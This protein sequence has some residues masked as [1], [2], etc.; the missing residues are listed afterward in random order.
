MDVKEIKENIIKCIEENYNDN[1]VSFEKS[2]ERDF[3]LFLIDYFEVLRKGIVAQKRTVHISRELKNKVK[4]SVFKE[5]RKRF[6]EI[7]S[8]IE[9]GDDLNPFLS[10][11]AKESGFKDRLLTCWNMHHLHFY[12][13][14]KSGDMLLFAIVKDDTVY[15]I[16]VIPHSKKYIFSTFELLNIV[17]K[18]WRFLLEPYRI[19]DAIS[20]EYVIKTDEE[21]NKLRSAGIS[22]AIQIDKNI[23]ALDMMST[24]G[25]NA[26]DVMYANNILNT[27]RIN[28]RNGAL[29]KMKLV[30]LAL[31]GKRKP[32]FILTYEDEQHNLLPWVI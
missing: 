9:N 22:T 19:K 23:Y 10:K 21:V 8:M 16:D 24:D 30:D 17:Y 3:H 15:M 25:H 32:C 31:T 20:L 2:D 18:N 7:K 29:K 12:P 1:K 6:D 13:E 27:I 28:E 26:L 4:S 5:W 11:K 14:K